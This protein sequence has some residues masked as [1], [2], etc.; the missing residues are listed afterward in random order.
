MRDQDNIYRDY[1]NC[2]WIPKRGLS[3]P[4]PKIEVWVLYPWDRR[5]ISLFSGDAPSL[6]NRVSN[7]AFAPVCQFRRYSCLPQ[8]RIIFSASYMRLIVGRHRCPLSHFVCPSLSSTRVSYP[9]L[10]HCWFLLSGH[11]VSIFSQCADRI[12][13]YFIIGGHVSRLQLICHVLMCTS[14]IWREG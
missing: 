9:K 7:Q 3:S 14:L 5:D 6:W 13:P 4:Q 2:Y 12:N 8:A 10:N 1:F 11:V